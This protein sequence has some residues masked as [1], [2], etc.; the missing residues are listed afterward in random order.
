M[1]G[2]LVEG[3]VIV[4]GVMELILVEMV[5][6]YVGILNGGFSVVFYGLV[7]LWLF[8]DDMFFMG[9]GGG[10]GEWIICEESV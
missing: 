10:I 5:G 4:F 9:S 1:I 8:G 2:E 3:F 7:E 6:V